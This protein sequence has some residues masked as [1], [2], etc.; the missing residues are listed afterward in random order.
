MKMASEL[1][2]ILDY[3]EGDEESVFNQVYELCKKHGNQILQAI[4]QIQSN[5]DNPYLVIQKDS[6]LDIVSKREY[7][8]PTTELLT[9]RI[10]EKLSIS[11]PLAFK[12][13]KPTNENDLNDKINALIQGDADDYGR[14]FPSVSFALA[15]TVPDHSYLKYGLL[16]ETKYLRGKTTASTITDGI[17]AD[18]IKY[19]EQCFILFILYDPERKI[20]NDEIFIADFKQKRSNIDIRIIR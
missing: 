3:I 12:V 11:I 6:F 8:K 2:D 5:Y 15:K 20:I 7:L 17:S 18:I 16:L 14:E 13:N 1:V 4:K 9:K 10:N 19:P